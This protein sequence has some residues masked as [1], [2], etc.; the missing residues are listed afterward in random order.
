[1][2]DQNKTC[3]NCK[4]DFTVEPEDFN[5]YKK[6][7]VPPPTWCPECRLLRR[8]IWRQDRTLYRDNCDLCGKDMVSVYHP[9]SPYV[10]YCSPCWWSDKYNPLDYGREYDFSR[11]FFEQ[12][13]DLLIKTPRQA[14]SLSKSVDCHYCDATLESKNCYLNFGSYRAEDCLY[15]SAPIMS[16]SC[17]DSDL[18]TNMDHAYETYNSDGM[19]NTKFVWFSEECFDSSFLFDCK[20]CS[21]CFG[22]VNLRNKKYHIF[23]KPYSKKDYNEKIK[24]WDLGSWKRVNEARDKFM[25]LL[26]VSP[27]RF[28]WIVNSVN[29][30]GDNIKNAKNCQ[31][32]FAT[33]NGVENCKFVLVAG[34]NVKD[35][36]DICYG[37]GTAELLYEN[38]GAIHGQNLR[39]SKGGSGGMD[40]E[41]CDQCGSSRH[42]FGCM[43][44]KGQSCCILNKQY[45]EDEYEKLVPKIRS[46][47]NEMPYTDSRGNTYSYGEYFP[48]E[49]SPWMYNESYAFQWFPLTKEETLK[50]GYRWREEKKRDYKITLP[51]DELPNH[52]DDV[53][54][55][56]I[57]ET[58]ECSH[59]SECNHQCTTAFKI[60][61]R[62]LQFYKEMNIALPRLCHNCRYYKRASLRNPLK[63]WHRGCTCMGK[64]DSKGRYTNTTPH[65]H[66]DKPCPNEFETSYSPDRKEIVYCESCY[67]SEVI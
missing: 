28:A 36:Y 61:P 46:H 20:G 10:V 63:L 33:I 54:E 49:L 7:K 41:Y 59:K 34:L 65:F 19:Y 15:C 31:T 55:S 11:P 38:T 1:M 2:S 37:G 62:E 50:K 42:T 14:T 26:N 35:S 16:R 67:R 8:L 66:K 6:I 29:V 57:N 53:P 51:S 24:Y 64:N 18:G 30:T 43:G 5:F 45:S 22:C 32:C 25:A 9:D 13:K 44:L 12:T 58:I 21:D 60:I 23:N 27:R 47:M 4:K 48:D 39:F 52:I 17:V 3:Q 56:I 40:Q